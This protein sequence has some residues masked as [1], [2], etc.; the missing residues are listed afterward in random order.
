MRNIP[1]AVICVLG[2][3]DN[4][5]PR[6]ERRAE[7]DLMR[8]T[9]RAGDPHRGDEDRYLML[10]TLLCARRYL[11]FSYCGRSLRDNSECQ[12]SVLLRELLDYIDG[13]V[14]AGEQAAAS[15]Q[16]SQLHPMQP[17]S[18]KNF[19]GEAAGYDR[20]WYQ[21]ACLL[22]Q[23]PT[24]PA[25]SPWRA[26]ALPAAL[27]ESAVPLESLVRFFQHPLRFFYN[28]R[29]GIRLPRQRAVE[30]EEAFSLQGLD[31]WSLAEQLAQQYLAGEPID[32]KLYS[33]RGLLPH[34]RA[35]DTAWFALLCEYHDLLER[36]DE[37]REV[38]PETRFIDCAFDDGN[39]LYGEIDA[40]YPAL[41]LMHFSASKAIKSRA[42][43]GL[44]LNHLA[45]CA[46]GQLPQGERSQLFAPATRGW[47]FGWIDS[48]AAR[49]QLTQ[50]LHLFEQGQQAPLPVFP[51]T[52]YAWASQVDPLVAM[53][54]ALAVWEGNSFNAAGSGEAADE[55]IQL[56]L[57]GNSAN[58][59]ADPL[60]QRCAQLIYGPAIE[61]GESIDQ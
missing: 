56:A 44:W 11:Y 46:T 14:P 33:A 9:W 47:Q 45:L 58:P 10:E 8:D 43:I 2:M 60:F 31:K 50:Y 26:T 28:N 35:A 48:T 17:F 23:V 55:F 3:Q 49:L 39:R 20:H 30:D 7:F 12:P 18:V 38:E 54:K 4:A 32:R 40:C 29:L 13:C 52:S 59:L 53:G 19:S 36:L 42:L 22:T 5:F 6:R 37:F 16:I 61:R 24:T 15:A 21:T 27:T 51:E 25:A 34:G 41:G 1:F 57:H